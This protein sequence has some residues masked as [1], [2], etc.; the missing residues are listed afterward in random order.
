MVRKNPPVK[1]GHPRQGEK[2][3]EVGLLR[4]K[5]VD[6]SHVGRPVCYR[7]D[8]PLELSCLLLD[9]YVRLWR[10]AKFSL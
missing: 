1:P 5:P 4:V 6:S 2:V 3:R 10:E 8:P 9:K 7:V